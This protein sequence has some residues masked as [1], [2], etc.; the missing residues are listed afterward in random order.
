MCSPRVRDGAKASD[1]FCD[2]GLQHRLVQ[3]Q[4][5]HDLL[6]LHV[7]FP[8]P[9]QSSQLGRPDAAVLL[10]PDVERRLAEA[11]LAAHLVKLVPSSFCFNAKAIWSSVDLIF[12]TTCSWPSRAFIMPVVSVRGTGSIPRRF[13][14]ELRILCGGGRKRT[15]EPS[16]T[17]TTTP[18]PGACSP[19]SNAS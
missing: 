15:T 18:W 14:A 17:P 19:A 4:V 9:A 3:A 10:F 5:G 16:A 1:F 2:D 8:E 11:H 13:G 6:E 7:F 12:L